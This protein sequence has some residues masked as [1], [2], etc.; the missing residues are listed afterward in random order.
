MGRRGQQGEAGA[1]QAGDQGETW[2][3]PPRSPRAGFHVEEEMR[4]HRTK[5]K[6]PTKE[7][8]PRGRETGR[9]LGRF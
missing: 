9:A 1:L 6:K 4:L 5:E 7:P 3:R 8:E 2:R